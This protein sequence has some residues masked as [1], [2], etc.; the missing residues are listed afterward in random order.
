MGTLLLADQTWAQLD[1]ALGGG[2]MVGGWLLSGPTG[3]GKRTLADALAAAHLSSRG[4]R[5]AQDQSVLTMVDEEAHPDLFVL[6]RHADPKTGK[7]PSVIQVDQVRALKN[8][9]FRTSTTGRR[10]AIVDTAD[11]MNVSSANA[12]LK[13]L[14]EPPEGTLFLLLSRAPGRLLPTITSRCR[15]IALRPPADGPATAWLTER[16][17]ADEA[18]ASEA[19]R[20]AGGAPGRALSLLEGEGRAQDLAASLLAAAS[21]EADPVTVASQAGAKANEGVW[22]EAWQI[23]EDRL[24][25]ALRGLPGEPLAARAGPA[26]M[27]ALGEASA[28]AR[29]AGGLNSDRTQTALML[30]RTLARGLH[31]D[32]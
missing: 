19:L 25:A 5:D 2:S 8:G 11:E 20:L 28:L 3:I 16:S 17:G 13:A 12:L 24:G 6:R 4:L 9:L 26:L 18:A 1:M 10:V 7:L 31:A 30:T 22:P 29:R 27:D 23:V 32:R 15:R 14:E 21:G